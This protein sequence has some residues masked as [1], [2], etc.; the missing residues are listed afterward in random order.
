MVIQT[1]GCTCAGDG[2]LDYAIG[3]G[4]SEKQLDSGFILEIEPSGFTDRLDVRKN[5][6][7]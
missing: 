6:Q 7:G 5:R 1:R 3:S 4:G 2:S